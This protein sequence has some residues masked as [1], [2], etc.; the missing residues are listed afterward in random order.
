MIMNKIIGP[1]SILLL[2]GSA[3]CSLFDKLIPDVDT[4][5]TKS[6][7]VRLSDNNGVTDAEFVDVKSSSDYN[8]FKDHIDGF[9]VKKITFSISDY[10]APSD[11]YFAGF[12]TAW[13]IDSTESIRIGNISRFKLSDIAGKGE[14]DNVDEILPGLKKVTA[15]LDS[16]GSFYMNA[17]F[18]LTDASGNPYSEKLDGYSFTL[19][20]I[21]YVTVK[22]GSK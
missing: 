5:Y 12:I 18:S 17:G 19:K 14:Q 6:F 16:P 11:L 21:Y 13:N 9:D 8:D 22:T 7:T 4:E 10:N 20:L 15:W 3:S 2:V 1:V